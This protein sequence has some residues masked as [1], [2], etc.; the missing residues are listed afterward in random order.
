M[1]KAPAIA[2]LEAGFNEL[3]ATVADLD[4]RTMS[5]PFYGTWNAKEVLGHIAGWHREMTGAMER[6]ARG[7]RPTPEGV[8]YSNADAWN[9]KFAAPMRPQNASTAVAEL[10]QSFANYLRAAKAIPDDRFG[11]GKTINR[12]LETSGTGHYQEHLPALKELKAKAGAKS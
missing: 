1:D 7:E 3:L 6:M 2:A 4:E 11:E 8:D 10:R 12:L 5:T 9:A